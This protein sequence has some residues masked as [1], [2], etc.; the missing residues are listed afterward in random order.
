MTKHIIFDGGI[1]REMTA[2]EIVNYKT[3]CAERITEKTIDAAQVDAQAAA[4]K[5]AYKKLAAIGLTADEIAAI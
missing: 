1:E 5:S 4:K 3:V 2:L